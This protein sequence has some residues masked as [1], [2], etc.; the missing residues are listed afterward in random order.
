[1]SPVKGDQAFV[2]AIPELYDRLLVPLI[3]EHYAADL[4]ARVATIG[5]AR[6]LEIAAGTGVLTR[7]LAAVLPAS[8]S[9]VSTD[10][11]APMLDR[12]GKIGTA[13]PV[14]WKV[15]DALKLPFEDASFDA[16]VCQFGVMFFP[17]K[18]R[19]Y[20]E[21]HRVLRPQGSFLFNVW[22]RIEE[23]ELTQLTESALERLFPG[24]PP[25]FFS[26]T[27]HGYRDSAV[28]ERHLAAGGFTDAVQI[29]TVTGRSRAASARDAAAAL[30]LGTPL[31]NEIEA[32]DASKLDAAVSCAAEAIARRAGNGPVDGKTQAIVFSVARNAR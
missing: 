23:N 14:Q 27:P 11:N 21:V 3:F 2:D 9:I 10:L 29:E 1:M 31:R 6:V 7:Q 32:R 16:V 24:D 12:A 26:R 17:D 19:A 28:I 20:S 5:P 25:R 4:A 13:R 22:D 8:T 30:C 15:A 18:V